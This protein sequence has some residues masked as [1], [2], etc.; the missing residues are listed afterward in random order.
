MTTSRRAALD[1][2]VAVEQGRRV[3]SVLWGGGRL[4]SLAARDRAFVVDLVHG[5]TRLR[6]ALDHIMAPYLRRDLDDDVRAAIRLGVYQLRYLDTP[7]HAAVHDT[8]AAAPRRARGLVNAVLRKVADA[9]EPA[10]PA[11]AV[12]HS[13][14]DWLWNLAEDQWGEDG[15]ACLVAMNRPQR[16]AAR[17]DGYVQ[18]RASA[19]VCEA[20]DRACPD[21]GVL[22]DMCA[23]PGGK[24]TG[25]GPQWSAVVAM[26]L[27]PGRVQ[28][29]QSTVR[30][31]GSSAFVVRADGRRP[32]LR[33]TTADAVLVDAPCSGLGA[34][35]R[36][37]DARWSVDL[38]AVERL[39]EVQGDMLD[40]ALGL[41]RPGGV[42]TYSVCTF[43]H[44]E[45]TGVVEGFLD[46]HPTVEVLPVAEGPW[47]P[48][49]SGGIVLAHDHGTDA[50][51]L[52]QFRRP[53]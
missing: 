8:V 7:A 30:G 22:V 9:P 35:G 15:T 33:E 36:R 47:R 40:A 37:S 50:M 53:G 16:P 31:L 2:L 17:T 51:A 26:D 5:V 25:V 48:H 46:R 43:T 38:G 6:R 19:W 34:L 39:T 44:E 49:G 10:W 45:T 21:G 13:Y 41:L 32:P 42:L 14:P 23:A 18:G 4:E 29:L 11:P 12:Q 1:A 52:F 27:D 24:T 28:T 3:G 20:V